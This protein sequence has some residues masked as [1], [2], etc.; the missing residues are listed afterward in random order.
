LRRA[1]PKLE[2]AGKLDVLEREYLES[3]KGEI[4]WVPREE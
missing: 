2:G 3:V 4:V 1:I